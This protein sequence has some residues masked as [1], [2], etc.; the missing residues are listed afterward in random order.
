MLSISSK[1]LKTWSG[2]TRWLLWATVLAWLTFGVFW[3]TMHWLIVPRIG[4]FRPLLEA[5]ASQALGVTVRVGAVSARSSGLT[6]SFELTDVALFDSMGR[7]ALSL[8][9][10]LV[11]LSPRSLWRLGFEQLYIDQPELD[12]RRTA[13]GRI[14][15]AGLDFSSPAGTSTVALDWFFSQV[16]FAIHDGTVRWTDEQRAAE[17]VQL[18]QVDLLVRNLGRHHDM[19]LDAT[20]PDVW[21]ARFN[22]QGRFLQPLLARRNG[23]WRDWEGQLF[24]A[25]EHVDLRELRRYAD[26]GF[27]LSQGRGA[28]RAWVDVSRGQITGATADVALSEVALTLA[29]DLQPMALQQLQGRISARVLSNGFEFATRS[30]M[31]DSPQGLHWPGGNVRV[32]SLNAQGKTPARGEVQADRLDLAAL[33][34]IAH[35]LPLDAGLRNALIRY[36]PKGQVDTLNASWQGTATAPVTYSAKGRLSQLEL[37][38]VDGAP[39]VRGLNLDFDLDQSAGRATLSMTNGSVDVPG[40][41]Q[42][43]LIS[44]DQMSANAKWQTVQDHIAVQLTG[45][46]FA[47]ADTQG[48]AQIKWQT[49]DPKKSPSKSRFPGILDLQAKLSR[50]EGRRVHRYLPLVIDQRA[51]DYVREAVLDGNASNVRFVVKGDIY[52]IP[53]VDA[54]RGEFRISADVKAARLA[55]VPP[56]LQEPN[57]LPW[58]ALND[59]SGELVIDRLQLMVKGARARLGDNVAVQVTQADATIA[60]LLNAE[61]AVSADFRGPAPVVLQMVNGSPL[62]ELTA[63]ALTRTVVSGNADYKLKLLLPVADLAKSSVQGSISMSGNDL[64]ISP[65]TPKLTRTRGVLHFTQRGFTLAGVQTRMLGGD[66]RLEG[67]LLLSGSDNSHPSAIRAAGLATAEGLRQATEL[68]LVARLAR[69]ISGSAAYN[70]SFGLR[71][72]VPEL[73]VTSNLQGMAASLPSPLTK[74]A[75]SLLP[76]RYQTASPVAPLSARRTPAPV[77]DRLTLTLGSLVSLTYE[78]DVSGAEPRVLRGAIGIGADTLDAVMLPEQGINANIHL[79]QFN[80]DAWADLLAQVTAAP[81]GTPDASKHPELAYLPSNLA[82]RADVLTF[83]T[84]QFNRLVLGAGRDGLLWRANVDSAELNGYLE[85]RQPDAANAN[86]A[87]AVYGR[88]TRLLITPSIANDVEALLDTESAS[89]PALDL[90]VDDFE[91]RGKRLGRLEVEA[92]NRL[93]SGPAGV[94]EW[95]LNKLN[96]SMPEATLTANGN[97]ARLNAQNGGAPGASNRPER[98]RTVMNFKLDIADGG[99]LLNRFGMKDVVRQA[100]GKIEGQLAWIGPPFSVDYPTLGGAVT[101]NVLSGQFLKADPGLAK[102]LGVLSLQ[103][104]PRRLVLDF[105]DVFSDGFAFDFLRGNVAVEKGLARTNNLQMKGINAA[106]LMEGVADIDRETQ[107]LKVVVVPELNAGTAALIATVINPAIGLGSFLAQ[108]FLSKPLIESATQE[109]HVN[110]SWADPKVTKVKHITSTSKEKP[111]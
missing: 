75:Q 33:T 90:L 109:F 60:D 92:V 9:R 48:E 66:A 98:H 99:K 110:G 50:A 51:R 82:V 108:L 105:R 87:G 5:Q 44:I 84:R 31:F 57:E 71:R 89:V 58:P 102:L 14:T 77:Q 88:L 20:P 64:Q 23:Q 6:P 47:N 61:V 76:L 106:V 107:D 62:A 94:N 103:A 27:D 52:D 96:L 35:R 11:A 53:A 37:A 101:V 104:L 39:G 72:G 54:R 91:L 56:G 97:W 93:G 40:I 67:G 70:A 18:Q 10:V 15:V 24:A 78:R 85:Y 59:L 95:R 55:Y 25:F 81:L 2:L 41:F 73:L 17:P 63:R 32:L 7:V 74:N 34:Q 1:L 16:E 3:A 4:E 100:S 30:L 42:E 28:L 68:G 12:I 19:R 22:V 36:A 49:S 8:P 65:D 21:G 83:G 26:P 13:D 86:S 69:Q 29:P 80:V 79:P 45:L 46:K 38:A 111:Q 43:G